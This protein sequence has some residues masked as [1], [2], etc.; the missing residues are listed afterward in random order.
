MAEFDLLD[1]LP[2]LLNRAAER[3]SLDFSRTYKDRYGLLRTEWRVLFHLG[4]FGELTATEIGTRAE[5]HKTKV[6]RAVARLEER[7]FLTRR[8]A[9]EDRRREYLRL[10]PAG[11]AAYRDLHGEAADYEARLLEAFSER[12]SAAL[13]K[14]LR[15]LAAL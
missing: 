9:E 14:A 4:I 1:F 13:R 7:R 15:R 8:P 2:Y 5:I 12:E 3:S 6:S 11:M 10:T